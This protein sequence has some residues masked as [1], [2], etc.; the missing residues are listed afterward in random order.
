MIN[1]IEKYV[2]KYTF[3]RY[4]LLI[5]LI[6]LAGQLILLREKG[7]LFDNYKSYNLL[8]ILNFTKEVSIF[9]L[10]IGVF[11]FIDI[12]FKFRILICLITANL[13]CY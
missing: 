7:L 11:I 2:N 4:T 13:I 12:L 3:L 5:Y 10:V 1:E 8:Y 6:S 9:L